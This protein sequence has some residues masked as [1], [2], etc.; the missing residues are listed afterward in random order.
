MAQQHDLFDDIIDISKSLDVLKDPLGGVT[1]ALLGK[2]E[3]QTPEWNPA[4]YKERPRFNAIP[5]LVCKSEKSTC[6]RCEEVCPVNAIEVDDGEVDISDACRKCGLC[7]PVCPTEAILSPRVQPKKIYDAVAKAATAHTTAYVTCTRALRRVPRENEVVIACVGDVTPE[8]WFAIMTDFPQVS[9]YLPLGICD[10]CRNAGGEEILGDAIAT[11]E[12]WSGTGMGLEVEPRAL[13]CQKRREYERKEFLDNI[14]RTTGLTVSKLNPAAAAVATVTQRLKEHNK[15]L[16]ALERT[17]AQATGTTT[18]KRRRVL[19]Q[20]RQL[21]LS[22]LQA[23]PKLAENIQITVPECDFSKCTMCGECVR[24]CPLHACDLVGAGRFALEPTYCVGC[25][26]CA[27]VCPEHAL[28]M[29]THEGTELVVPD[30]EAERKALEAAQAKKDAEKMKA[31]AK[32]K[33]SKVLD[34][35]EKLA[36]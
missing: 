28:T 6:R 30:P 13:V 29:A 23:H 1:D 24:A 36:D 19:T 8:T 3:A 9:V 12:E 16:S 32:Q 7:V 20:S 27:E 35:V 15:K 5:C 26:L 4:D 34:Q 25:G 31:E 18:Q 10:K 17:L 2:P 11:A 22:T 21:L 33:I 14:K